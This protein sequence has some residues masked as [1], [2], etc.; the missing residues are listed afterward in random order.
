MFCFFILLRI[1]NF[2]IYYSFFFLPYLSSLLPQVSLFPK[3][4]RELRRKS[5]SFLSC[6]QLLIA[7]TP[8]YPLFVALRVGDG[9][10]ANILWHWAGKPRCYMQYV[11]YVASAGI[12]WTGKIRHEWIF[13]RDVGRR[14]G[15]GCRRCPKFIGDGLSERSRTSGRISVFY[16]TVPGEW[17]LFD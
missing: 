6:H 7:T 11:L 17:I 12:L 13:G 15:G 10:K 4:Q 9:R 5:R 8:F 2:G 3:P 16:L 1:W 14:C